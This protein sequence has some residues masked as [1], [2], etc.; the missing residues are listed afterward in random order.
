MKRD[1]RKRDAPHSQVDEVSGEL[2]ASELQ[3]LEYKHPSFRW[4]A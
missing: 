1:N 3:N 2:S 4:R